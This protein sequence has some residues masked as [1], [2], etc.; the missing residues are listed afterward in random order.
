MPKGGE[1]EEKKTEKKY[2]L[3]LRHCATHVAVPWPRAMGQITKE[4]G[5]A[6]SRTVRCCNDAVDA[7]WCYTILM[8]MCACACVCVCVCASV[9]VKDVS[10]ATPWYFLKA[11]VLPA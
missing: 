8:S 5:G 11:L 1:E 3:L 2:V 10:E 4:D 6:L 9:R 7:Y